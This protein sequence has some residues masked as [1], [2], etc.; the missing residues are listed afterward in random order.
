[1][2]GSAALVAATV[3]VPEGTADG[4]TYNPDASTVPTVELPPLTPFTVH[5]TPVFV[6]PL[7]VAVNCCVCPTWMDVLVGDTVTD[8]VWAIVT[9]ASADFVGSAEL[10]AATVTAEG[11]RDFDPPDCFGAVYIPEEDTVPTVEFPPASPLTIQ[12]T[13]VFDVPAIDALNCW[14]LPGCTVAEVGLIETET[15][16]KTVIVA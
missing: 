16:D 3:T 12:F 8:T 4:A 6:V 11:S 14:L 10:T 7:T 2:V 15:V 9:V 1:M 13:T 5:V